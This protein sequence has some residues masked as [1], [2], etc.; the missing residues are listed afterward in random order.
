MGTVL[1][2]GEQ[3]HVGE[4]AEALRALGASVAEV[5]EL[6]Q[7]S[8]AC[9]AAGREA[10]DSYVQL[11]ASF[12]VRGDTAVER[13]RHFYA[14]GVLARFTALKAVLPS[15]TGGARITFVLGR[16]PDEASTP[17]DRDARL[18]LTKILAQAARADVPEG[19]LVARVLDAD[20]TPGEIARVA[21]GGEPAEHDALDRLADLSYADWRVE[22][23]GL[24]SMET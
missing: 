4:V 10:F 7:I 13:V 12:H 22:L 24:V 5:S 16:L 14:E 6:E 8:A 15:L 23:L 17:D 20:A 2:S 9:A 3:G 1:V 19:R 11:A 18:A 21:L